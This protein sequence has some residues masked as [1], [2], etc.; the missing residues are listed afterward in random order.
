MTSLNQMKITKDA[1]NVLLQ[2]AAHVIGYSGL[3]D[4]KQCHSLTRL[5]FLTAIHLGG[6]RKSAT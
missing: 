6:V 1:I 3:L 4:P 2:S 5:G